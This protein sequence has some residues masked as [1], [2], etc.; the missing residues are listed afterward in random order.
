MDPYFG[1]YIKS[2]EVSLCLSLS[3]ICPYVFFY[4]GLKRADEETKRGNWNYA[5]GIDNASFLITAISVL[6]FIPLHFMTVLGI[7]LD[8]FFPGIYGGNDWRY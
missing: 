5:K 1:D 7:T 8:T 6:T 4:R 2:F 3:Y